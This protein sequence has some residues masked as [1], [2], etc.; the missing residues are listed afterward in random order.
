MS[1]SSQEICNVDIWFLKPQEGKQELILVKTD[2]NKDE[3]K[4]L[5][6]DYSFDYDIPITRGLVIEKVDSKKRHIKL[7]GVGFLIKNESTGRY[8]IK[9]I[10]TH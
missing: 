4:T 10:S 7:D 9:I 1:T 2:K 5:K 6:S 3:P 8:L